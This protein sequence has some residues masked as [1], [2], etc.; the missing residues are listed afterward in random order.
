M[1]TRHELSGGRQR[2]GA[3]HSGADEHC[4]SDGTDRCIAR[5]SGRANA[6][7]AVAGGAY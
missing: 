4:S 2:N 7:P 6:Q 3:S 1:I 5:F